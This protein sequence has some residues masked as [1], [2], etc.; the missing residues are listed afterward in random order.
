MPATPPVSRSFAEG[1]YFDL[2][3]LV[4]LTSGVAGGFSNVFWE[5]PVPLVYGLSLF[6]MLVWEAGEYL[7][8][9]RE[10]WSN[11]IIDIVVGMAGVAIAERA[12]RLMLPS[13]ELA[14]FVVTLGLSLGG[15]ALGVR[16]YRRR[17]AA[18]GA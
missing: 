14:A 17:R 11:R 9:I 4:H 16:A 8:R 7:S 3:M 1:R 18:D 10:E 15:M 5:L 13:Q 12:S 6:L 2:W